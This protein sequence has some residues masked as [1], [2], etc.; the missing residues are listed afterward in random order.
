ME[1]VQ[2]AAEY[3]ELFETK[4]P[5]ENNYCIERAI[6]VAKTTLHFPS[7]TKKLK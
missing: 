2:Q 4:I 7:M 1:N 5:E 3:P 6:N